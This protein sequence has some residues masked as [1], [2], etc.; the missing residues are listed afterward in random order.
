MK[1]GT[2]KKDV[3]CCDAGV[4]S[5]GMSCCKVE[6]LITMDGRGQIVLPKDVR[7]KA[8]IKAGD[9]LAVISWESSGQLCCLSLI[10]AQDFAETVK[11]MLGPMMKEVLLT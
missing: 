5:T 8:G 6:A 11:G 3:P 7:D 10:K 1:K 4:T 9:K 2:A